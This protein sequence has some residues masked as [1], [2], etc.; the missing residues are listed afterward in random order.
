M[1]TTHR[2]HPDQ[3]TE[4]YQYS[5]NLFAVTTHPS[6]PFSFYNLRIWT[7]LLLCK[8]LLKLVEFL[9]IFPSTIQSFTHKQYSFFFW[10]MYCCLV[11]LVRILD[12]HLAPSESWP[13]LIF[14]PYFLLWIVATCLCICQAFVV[15]Y[16]ILL[17]HECYPSEG[18]LIRFF[19]SDIDHRCWKWSLTYLK[20]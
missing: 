2:H 13:Q 6:S 15:E 8:C 7:L 4:N 5:R 9:T 17:W 10:E 14:Q 18:W 12:G 1:N 19:Y 3:E 16:S 11:A 20:F